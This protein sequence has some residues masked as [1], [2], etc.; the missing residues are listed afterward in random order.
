MRQ[1]ERREPKRLVRRPREAVAH[2]A[3]ACGRE[4]PPPSMVG[5]HTPVPSMA[6]GGRSGRAVPLHAR[7]SQWTGRYRPPW[8]ALAPRALHGRRLKVT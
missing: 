2:E 4:P 8:S 7:K 3:G 6:V 5:A 1:P